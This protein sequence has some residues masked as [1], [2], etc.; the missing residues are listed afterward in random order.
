MTEVNNIV[1]EFFKKYPL[2]EFKRGQVIIS[3][4]KTIDSTYYLING[5]VKQY[6]IS[7]DGRVKAVNIYKPCSYFPIVAALANFENKYFYE[8]INK[9]RVY[10][11]PSS[12][13]L[14]FTKQNSEVIEDLLQR[15]LVGVDGVLN[16]MQSIMYESSQKKLASFILMLSSRFG[17]SKGNAITIDVPLTHQDLASFTGMIRETVSFEMKK[18]QKQGIIASNNRRK[19]ITISNISALKKILD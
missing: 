12:E 3:P 4:S 15:F 18:L 2:K 6:T 8:A 19:N 13:V 7:K 1:K 16:I 5:Y 14:G 10:Q 17:R 9:V 11:A